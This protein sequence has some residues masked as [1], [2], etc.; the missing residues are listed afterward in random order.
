MLL[1]EQA[2]AAEGMDL[3]EAMQKVERLNFQLQAIIGECLQ[4]VSSELTFFT[5]P[6]CFELF[7]FDLL[8]DEDWRVWLLEANAEPDFM[9]VNH[10]PSV[11]HSYCH[12]PPNGTLHEPQCLLETTLL[13]FQPGP[14]SVPEAAVCGLVSDG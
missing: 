2:L 13:T 11:G 10:R 9:Q 6:T 3:A 14:Q 8:V 12:G 4:A 5:L 7:G 1:C